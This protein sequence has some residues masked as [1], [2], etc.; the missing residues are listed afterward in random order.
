MLG[1]LSDE[2]IVWFLM[3][4]TGVVLVAMLT[5]SVVM[6]IMST[7]RAGSA[8]WPRFATQMLHRNVSL[9]AVA[10]LAAHVIAAVVHPFVNIRWFDTFI[11]FVGPYQPLKVGIGSIAFDLIA[12]VTITSLFRHR[13]DHRGWRAIHLTSYLAW[14]LGLVHGIAIGTD[15]TATWSVVITVISIGAVASAGVVRLATW[16]HERRVAA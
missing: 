15:A 16:A 1:L 12:V 2:R 13:L 8:R 5:L 4:G 3:R 14:A 6:G 10:L 9:M 7:A 11:P